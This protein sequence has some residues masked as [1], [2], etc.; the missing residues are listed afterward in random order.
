MK[1]ETL[2]WI[3]QIIFL[4]KSIVGLCLNCLNS[5][6]EKSG[7][8]HVALFSPIPP[9]K[10]GISIYSEH[11]LDELTKYYK[12]DVFV[13]CHYGKIPKGGNGYKVYGYLLFRILKAIRRYRCIVYQVG[14]NVYHN[15]MY[16]TIKRTGGIVVLHDGINFLYRKD[17]VALLR[18]SD[19][20]VHNRSSYS[21]V[22]NLGVTGRI[23]EIPL[24]MTQTLSWN[25]LEYEKK[26]LR[27]AMGI[28]DDVLVIGAFG[29]IGPAKHIN[30]AL[31]AASEILSKEDKFM[32]IVAGYR[33]LDEQV[34]SFF[35]SVKD[36]K[37]YI[38][39][40]S[41]SPQDFNNCIMVTDIC[42]NLRY[43]F[44][45]ETSAA[46]L[47]IMSY[48]VASIVTDIGSFSDLPDNCVIK[49]SKEIAINEYKDILNKSKYDKKWLHNVGENAYSYIK[50]NHNPKVVCKKYLDFMRNSC[51][52]N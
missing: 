30:S 1:E 49:T 50:E 3:K 39:K 33:I 46:L 14:Y 27:Y 19:V 38:L 8:E 37:R 51:Q 32:F 42:F 48:G 25:E 40:T 28:S 9:V 17:K 31:T 2:L 4:F 21:D 7:V 23:I 34:E 45:G 26:K 41:L 13:D 18:R 10:S 5:S 11:L 12:I 43:P 20:I 24:I 29:I 36:D 22:Q 52:R 16:P 47:K 44:Y 35:K 15:Y 6:Y